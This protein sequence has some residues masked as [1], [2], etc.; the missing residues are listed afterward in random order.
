LI[1]VAITLTTLITSE[2]VIIKEKEVIK[3]IY[4]QEIVDTTEYGN[5]LNETIEIALEDDIYYGMLFEYF[6]SL[7]ND[8]I[9]S[10]AIIDAALEWDIPI[11]IA[12]GMAWTESNFDPRAINNFNSNK[13]RDWGLFQLNDS[14]REN[15][16]KEDFFNPH[17]NAYEAMRYLSFVMQEHSYDIYLGVAA[18]NAGASAVNEGISVSTLRYLS[19]VF[20]YKDKVEKQLNNLLLTHN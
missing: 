18:Y 4:P 12:F 7:T 9:I 10:E 15:W 20:K 6:N 14:Y 16:S 3:E 2:E 8:Q 1:I 11:G 13:T 19:S 5:A 17:K